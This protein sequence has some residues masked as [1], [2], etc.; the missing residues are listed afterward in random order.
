MEV[1]GGSDM[2]MAVCR[3]CHQ[4]AEKPQ[5]IKKEHTPL[6]G[7]DITIGRHLDFDDPHNTSH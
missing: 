2:Y 1:I 5:L 3:T 6:R 7:G 4:L